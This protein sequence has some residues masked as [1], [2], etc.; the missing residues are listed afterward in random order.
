M[1]ASYQNFRKN[2]NTARQDGKIQSSV[3]FQPVNNNFMRASRGTLMQTSNSKEM[4]KERI[5]SAKTIDNKLKNV[6][7]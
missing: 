7:E 1:T 5:F 2:M 4:A 3:D 6:R